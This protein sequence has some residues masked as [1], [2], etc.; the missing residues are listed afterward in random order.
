MRCLLPLAIRKRLYSRWGRYRPLNSSLVARELL[1]DFARNDPTGFHRFLWSH[2]TG[3]LAYGKTYETSLRFGDDNL[4]VSRRDLIT[5][6]TQQLRERGVAPERDVQSVF[7]AGCSLGYVLRFLEEHIFPSATCLRGMDV[8]QSAIATGSSYLRHRGSKIELVAAD[9]SRLDQVM[10][11]QKFDVV[12][13]CGVLMYLDEPTAARAVGTMLAHTRMLL[14][15]ISLANLPADNSALPHSTVRS[16]DLAFIHN[17]DTMVEKAGGKVVARR[18]TGADAPD[19]Y[20][21]SPPLFILAEPG[22]N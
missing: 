14:G 4:R 6:I 12:L 19:R 2:H 8:D 1:Q 10:G 15:L 13:C 9:I 18:W 7:D 21:H 11:N 16:E 5:S 20:S 17:V 22:D 3:G